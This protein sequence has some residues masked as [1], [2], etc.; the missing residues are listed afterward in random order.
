MVKSEL[1]VIEAPEIEDWS[2]IDVLNAQIAEAKE[3]ISRSKGQLDAKYDSIIQTMV[4]IEDELKRRN[5]IKE[6]EID[7][8]EQLTNKQL[9]KKIAQLAHTD[10]L[11]DDKLFKRAQKAL[12]SKNREKLIGL[13]IEARA[14]Y[15]ELL[16]IKQ[17]EFE[18]VISSN[19][20][21]LALDWFSSDF[22]KQS[23]A[24]TFYLSVL[25]ANLQSLQS[26]L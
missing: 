22:S 5:V 8:D 15:K 18:E 25:M 14:D 10:K 19:E 1:I 23:K 4:R 13:L 9:F 16:L 6:P 2:I 24:E 12:K 17:K 11:G 7:K 26:K 3:L 20:Y 21:L